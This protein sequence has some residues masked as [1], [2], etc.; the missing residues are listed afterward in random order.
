MFKSSIMRLFVFNHKH[1]Q[2]CILGTNKT[3]QQKN[4]SI[5]LRSMKD[6]VIL[7]RWQYRHT[8]VGGWGSLQG[9]FSSTTG[10]A[11]AGVGKLLD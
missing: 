7:T 1:F 6:V 11:R 5:C 3:K 10:Q 4:D 9:C 2:V 8:I